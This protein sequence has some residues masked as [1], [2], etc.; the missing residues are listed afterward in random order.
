MDIYSVTE[1][2]GWWIEIHE[3]EAA[4]APFTESLLN[5]AGVRLGCRTAQ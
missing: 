5:G 4:K 1:K 2:P 3:T